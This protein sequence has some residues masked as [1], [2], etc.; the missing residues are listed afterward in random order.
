MLGL[1]AFVNREVKRPRSVGTSSDGEI[2]IH[3]TEQQPRYQ[4][5]SS[6]QKVEQ[7]R[8]TTVCSL[9]KT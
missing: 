9:G 8:R 1:L 3:Q 2:L 6:K 5:L 4:L 7:T